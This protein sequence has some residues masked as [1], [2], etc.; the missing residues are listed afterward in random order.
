VKMT[1]VLNDPPSF[2]ATDVQ[3]APYGSVP[4][5]TQSGGGFTLDAGD[6]RILNVEWRADRLVATQTVGLSGLARAR[7]Y[8]FDTSGGS[9]TFTQQ[10]T[11]GPPGVHT[12]YPSIAIAENG[13]LG[14]TF[15]Q[16]SSKH[17]LSMY[18]TGQSV[19]D[20]LGTTQ[21]PVLARAGARNYKAFDCTSKDGCRAGDY[22]GITVDPSASDTF[23]AANEYATSATSENWGTWIQCFTLAPVHDLAVTAVKASKT[24]KNSV[25]S[26]VT[27]T[28]QNRSEHS[29]TIASGDLGDGFNTGL[30]R[31]NLNPID[32]DNESCGTPLVQLNSLKNAAL[33]SAGN[34]ILPVGKTI[35]VNFLVTY[36]CS[37]AVAV[38]GDPSPN[39]YSLSAS[40]H[41]EALAGTVGD[42]HPDDD[43][44]PRASL[45]SDPNPPPAGILD[46]GCG[47]KTAFGT[48]GGPIVI[49]VLP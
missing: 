26:P 23:C 48:P 45:G 38:K 17:F 10:S 4:N 33:F 5:A 18:V 3:V 32:D 6:T 30:V 14:L 39:D 43:S 21:T 46:K 49:N 37:T 16:S 20:P 24:A 40:V 28:I 31:L 9:P 36:N 41:H 2:T 15:M 22:S 47:A 19:G 7:W 29:E 8:E 35:S 1:S 34:K 25:P 27:V 44:C 12:Y 13:D 42:T 11:I